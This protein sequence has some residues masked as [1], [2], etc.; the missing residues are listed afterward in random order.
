MQIVEF[1][2]SF[3]ISIP[4]NYQKDRKLEDVK[5]LPTRQ[6]NFK[7]KVWEV[8]LI[9]RADI[10]RIA[11]KYRAEYIIVGNVEP[12]QIGNI[13]PMPELEIELPIKAELRHY[14]KQGIAK[15]IQLR[16]LLNGDEPGLGKTIQSI[17][18]IIGIDKVH[19][20]A[21]PCLCI[22]PASLKMNWE[23]EW[24]KFSD[25][26]VM[27]LNDKVKDNWQNYWQLGLA[28]VFI[29]NYESLKKF[30]VK[31]YPKRMKNA[32]DIEMDSRIELFK[33]VIVDES[34]KCKS[35]ATQQSKLTLRMAHGKE[36][37]ILLSG[38]PVVNKPADLFPQI[39]IMNRLEDFGGRRG[40]LNRYCEGGKG[41]S[42]L[43][44]L[45][46]L[47]NKHCYFR[48]EKKDVLDDLPEKE[49]QTIICEISTRETYEKAKNDF[50]RFLRDNGCNSEEI[51]RKLRGEIMV[52]MG[53]LKRISARGKLDA[54]FDFV[55][56]I[57]EAGEKIILF[58]N[59]HEIVDAL[60]ERYPKAVSVTG[61]SSMDE[62]QAAVD[63]F[64]AD[65]NTKILIGNIKAAGVGLTLTAS[66][67]VAF[68]EFPWTYADCVQCEDRAHRFGQKNNVMCTYFLG[69]DTIDEQLYQMIQSKRHI[70]NTISGATDKME[71]S[72]V[73]NVMSLFNS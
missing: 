55:D 43:K 61:L 5:K 35:T 18:T 21:F 34:H 49:R 25:K 66:S 68:I 15:G 2:D 51:R 29:V 57:T 9:Y 24:K 33:S 38:T 6:W 42:N 23:R 4:F 64:Q 59:L 40:F 1:K 12:E 67:R 32:G 31:N 17:G 11:K 30:F 62:K 36:N 10:E 44:E 28:D 69:K 7:K 47:L 27:I 3:H 71:M 41:A 48:R 46:Y 54:V 14:Q 26:K 56:E 53:E 60:K 50:V 70:A 39:A 52:K 20:G 13:E 63:K 65:P 73:D 58:C 72:I 22:V 16:R 37:V 45:N 19:G 8:P